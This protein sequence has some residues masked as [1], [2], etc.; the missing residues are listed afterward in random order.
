MKL[1]PLSRRHRRPPGEVH[2]LLGSRLTQ[3]GELTLILQVQVP[4]PST[5]YTAARFFRIY[6][7][8]GNTPERLKEEAERLSQL[9]RELE[10]IDA[11]VAQWIAEVKEWAESETHVTGLHDLQQ[12]IESPHLGVKQQKQ[13]IYCLLNDSNK[14]RHCI[15]RRLTVDKK[16]L[17]Q[18][19][20]KYN[21]LVADHSKKIDM[22]LV[23]QSLAGQS[24]DTKWLLEDHGSAGVTTVSTSCNHCFKVR[25]V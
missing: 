18:G 25:I 20:E 9:K 2:S 19:T 1:S 22:T 8:V 3:F 15:R 11:M 4:L 21:S 7:G 10:C 14:L 13:T 23:D 12:S 16:R 6:C 5:P 17:F 24:T